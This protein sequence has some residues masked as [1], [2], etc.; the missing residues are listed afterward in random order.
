MNRVLVTGP[1]GFVGSKVCEQLL[2]DELS[3]RGALRSGASKCVS[4]EVREGGGAEDGGAEDE[5]Q[6][7]NSIPQTEFI[8]VGD[9]NAQTDWF[10]ALEG[11]DAIV[12]LAARVHIMDDTAEDPLEAFR[13]V[14]VE[15]T[16]RLAQEAARAG[17]RRLVFISSI[18]VNGEQ[19]QSPSRDQ[20]SEVG[21]QTGESGA[22][23]GAEAVAPPGS[24]GSRT[25]TT[26]DGNANCKPQTSNLKPFFSERDKPSPEDP[27][28]QSKH[29][30]E[31]ALREIE[32]STGMEVVILRPPLLYGPGVKANFLKLIQ[33]VDK[34]IPLP[35]GAVNN[36]RSL[37][38]LT[39]FADVISKCV[40]DER[41]A[42][43]TFLVSDGDD[44]STGELV[45]RIATALGKSPRLLPVPEGL[46]KLA[47]KLTGK[48]AQ[49]QRL[50]SSLQIGSS[51][52]RKTLD[53]T[54]PVSMEQELARV[55]EWYRE[56]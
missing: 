24:P 21:G 34:G 44:I 42:G 32:A 16:R 54:P 50:C 3:V 27:Y 45:R 14:N 55:A 22:C 35:L 28:G 30:A 49:V 31:V 10:Q 2:A 12:H 17:V 36:K 37:L 9:I 8:V 7:A 40:T 43:Q 39:N 23:E 26:M 52:V 46:M 51:K 20:R 11:I 4:S 1:D 48:S 5:P 6:T 53:W 29:E 38:S 13:A 41:A 18:K 56:L 19:T 15:G 25:P 33:L 47:G